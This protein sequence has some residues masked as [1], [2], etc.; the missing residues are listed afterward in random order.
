[1]WS[2]LLSRATNPININISYN[3]LWVVNAF[4]RVW[5]YL[6]PIPKPRADN[7]V[8]L[9]PTLYIPALPSAFFLLQF[10]EMNLFHIRCG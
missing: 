1:M 2:Y 8:I 6:R 7:I 5:N 3:P 4:P 10:H 9:R